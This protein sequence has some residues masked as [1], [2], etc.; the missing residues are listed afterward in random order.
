MGLLRWVALGTAGVVAYTFWK[1]RQTETAAATSYRYD[2]HSVTSPHGDPLLG[3]ATASWDPEPAVSA[4]QSSRG[5]GSS[6]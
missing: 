4:S 5:F 6:Y 2:D 1:Q 3:T